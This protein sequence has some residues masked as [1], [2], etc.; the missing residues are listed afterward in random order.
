M[1]K[2]KNPKLMTV[3]QRALLERKGELQTEE[4]IKEELV[5]LPTGTASSTRTLLIFVLHKAYIRN[6][7]LQGDCNDSR[8]FEEKRTQITKEERSGCSKA[9]ER[10]GSCCSYFLLTSTA[11]MKSF[12]NNGTLL[13]PHL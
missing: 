7:R 10:K 11:L 13:V 6:L 9:R 1:K 4:V 5:A 8:T 3:R 12:P 2:I